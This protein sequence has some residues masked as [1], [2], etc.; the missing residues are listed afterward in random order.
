MKTYI[1]WMVGK[2]IDWKFGAFYNISISLDK[3]A[4]YQN[5]KGYVQ[6]VMSPRKETWK[7]WETETFTLNEWKPKE[8]NSTEVGDIEF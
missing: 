8:N 5:D 3:L 7:Y 6:I 2:K 4:E 1:N